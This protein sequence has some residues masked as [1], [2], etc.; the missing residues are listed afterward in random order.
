M[1]GWTSSSKQQEAPPEPTKTKEEIRLEQTKIKVKIVDLEWE[2]FV[3]KEQFKSLMYINRSSR[4]YPNKDNL[5]DELNFKNYMCL[6]IKTT[7]KLF[8]GI[9]YKKIKLIIH[10]EYFDANNIFSHPFFHNIIYKPNMVQ[11]LAIQMK[12]VLKK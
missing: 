5:I 1:K 3:L 9:T 2:Y 8:I 6:K 10:P 4:G 11:D 12:I 7:I